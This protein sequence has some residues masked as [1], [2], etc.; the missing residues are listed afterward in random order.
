MRSTCHFQ[1]Q[2]PALGA[3]G[4][5]NVTKVEALILADR[6]FITPKHWKVDLLDPLRIVDADIHTV[7]VRL[8]HSCEW[9]FAWALKA[10]FE[11]VLR[12]D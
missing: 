7:K 11:T 12:G 10:N 9:R 4:F 5:Y 3:L 6:C 2:E 8:C 1:R